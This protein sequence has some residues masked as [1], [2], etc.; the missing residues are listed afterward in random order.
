MSQHFNNPGFYRINLIDDRGTISLLA[1]P[2]GPK[3]LTAVAGLGL[4]TSRHML[5]A[6]AKLDAEWIRQ[7]QSQIAMFDEFNV[8]TLDSGWQEMVQEEDTIVHP[9]FRVIDGVTRSRSLVPGSLGLIVFNM[10]QRRIIQVHNSWDELSRT[11]EGRYRVDGDP[12]ERKFTYALPETW[13]LVP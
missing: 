11:G 6:V 2:H 5:N 7:V 8:D 13:S 12:E 3:M 9:A 4:E 10:K 1:P